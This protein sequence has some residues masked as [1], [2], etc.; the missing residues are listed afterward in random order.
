MT[1]SYVFYA[2][3]DVL[4]TKVLTNWACADWLLRKNY[5]VLLQLNESTLPVRTIQVIR[6]T[7]E[8]AQR[9]YYA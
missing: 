8:Y 6:G 7:R 4:P 9:S 5:G 3:Y 1:L 2:K